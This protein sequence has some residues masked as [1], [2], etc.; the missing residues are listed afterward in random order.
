MFRP[1]SL[2]SVRLLPP[3]PVMSTRP[4]ELLLRG[5]Q[6]TGDSSGLLVSKGGGDHPP[7]DYSPILKT[8]HGQSAIRDYC[9]TS[10]KS[11]TARVHLET[12]PTSLAR[13]RYVI[14]LWTS[15]PYLQAPSSDQSSDT[16]L[17]HCR[18]NYAQLPTSMMIHQLELCEIQTLRIGYINL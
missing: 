16:I 9:K 5:R 7:S 3:Q 11:L 18:H 2:S 8:D 12:T 10:P 4:P 13:P 1:V 14:R 17:V 15:W 6:R